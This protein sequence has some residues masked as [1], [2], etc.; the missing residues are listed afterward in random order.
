M[1]L[2]HQYELDNV[3]KDR[4]N[5]LSKVR[6][7]LCGVVCDVMIRK[8]KERKINKQNSEPQTCN[9]NNESSQ[10]KCL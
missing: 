2:D 5:N 7:N 1:L 4:N 10:R 3:L 8:K 6:S 9:V